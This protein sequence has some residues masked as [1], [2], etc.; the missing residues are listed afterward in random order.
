VSAA[1]ARSNIGQSVAQLLFEAGA[2]HISRQLPFILAAGWASPVYVDCRLLIGKP[3]TRRAVTELSAA[4][5]A[6]AFPARSFDAIAGA[7]TAGIP[8]ATLLAEQAGLELRYVRKRPL[9]IGRNAQV[10]G[11]PVDGLRVLLMDD[12]T[13]DGASKLAFARGLRSAGA[14][15][16]HALTI[17][18]NNAFSGAI[19]R[20]NEARLELHALATWTDVLQ[21]AAGEHLPAEDRA[22]IE[23]FLADPVAW[24]TRHGGRAARSS[25]G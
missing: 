1:N 13:T 14:S 24:S 8:F 20:L 3:Q 17:F 25:R 6:A 19:E 2:I 18:Y 23:H 12:L 22:A 5:L 16:E 9:G 15:V 21:S 10:E 11:G 4:Y 7:E